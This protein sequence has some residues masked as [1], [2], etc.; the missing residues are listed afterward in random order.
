[1][2]LIAVMYYASLKAHFKPSFCADPLTKMF[3]STLS[4]LGPR[5]QDRTKA[6]ATYEVCETLLEIELIAFTLFVH[7]SPP[8]R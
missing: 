7:E 4:D 2:F 3:T 1:M 8:W 6:P 5:V